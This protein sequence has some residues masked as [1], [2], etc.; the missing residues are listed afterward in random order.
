MLLSLISFLGIHKRNLN[1]WASVL[2]EYQFSKELSEIRTFEFS[3]D[4]STKDADSSS[5]S[6][7]TS[8]DE[9][10][11]T[12]EATTTDETTDSTDTS[13]ETAKVPVNDPSALTKENYEKVKKSQRKD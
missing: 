3:V 6:T 4:T 12:D 1:T 5:D 9:T 2:P 7:E 10:T 11:T 8:N 13:S